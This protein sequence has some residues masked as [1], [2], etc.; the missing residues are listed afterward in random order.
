VEEARK[1][2]FE[3]TTVGEVME[4]KGIISNRKD[5]H[6]DLSGI[7]REVFIRDAVTDLVKR[8]ED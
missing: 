1:R 7:S 2:G 8:V 5:P 6:L 4:E 3:T